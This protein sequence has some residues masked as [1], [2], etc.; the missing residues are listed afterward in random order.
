MDGNKLPKVG[1]GVMLHRN[2]KVLFG[3]RNDDPNKASSELHGEGTWTMP[4]G[5]LHFQ[6]KIKDAVR[7]EVREETSLIINQKDLEVIN[8]ADNILKDVHFVTVGYL[9]KKFKGKVKVMEPEEITVWKWFDLDKLP[10][11]VY[12]PSREII[13]AYLKLRK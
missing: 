10:R 12:L 2:G 1:F 5:K 11:K 4:G 7:R 8:I 3:K 9:C 13:V 6:E